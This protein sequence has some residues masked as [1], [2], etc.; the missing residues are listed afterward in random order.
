MDKESLAMATQV[1]LDALREER[2]AAI[3]LAHATYLR[4]V[5]FLT[6]FGGSALEA[7]ADLGPETED[8]A[9]ERP[10]YPEKYTDASLIDPSLAVSL[11][12]LVYNADPVPGVEAENPLYFIELGANK[13]ESSN[14]S[15]LACDVKR[16]PDPKWEWPIARIYVR[17][18]GGG[19]YR[20]YPQSMSNWHDIV[21]II[22]QMSQ[23]LPV[24]LTVGEYVNRVVKHQ[25]EAGTC[26]C[27]KLGGDGSWHPA[28]TTEQRKK[29]KENV[30][31]RVAILT[32]AAEAVRIMRVQLGDTDAMYSADR[33]FILD[34]EEKGQES[35]VEPE[36]VQEQQATAAPA[37]EVQIPRPATP[38][39][40][41]QR[42]NVTEVQ[43]TPLPTE[44]LPQQDAP[45]PSQ[46]PTPSAATVT[47]IPSQ[48]SAL[49][50]APP[51]S[52]LDDDVTW[53]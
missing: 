5:T 26:I 46:E 32:E 39:E 49:P 40:I 45:V 53:Q 36:K 51:A 35:G 18:K 1:S 42:Q 29:G 13:V 24:T 6:L 7:L 44:Q 4:R 19:L 30:D 20:Y 23:S 38:A 48:V 2:Q 9:K 37:K 27:E 22:R 33:P 21:T 17:F 10:L 34:L 52:S 47:D 14:V 3:N 43:P 31:A 11:S 28:L 25:H 8:S 15:A 12:G 41:E 50:P 16:H